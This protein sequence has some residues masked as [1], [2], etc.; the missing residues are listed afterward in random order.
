MPSQANPRASPSKLAT[1]SRKCRGRDALDA[2][3]I[4]N[5]RAARDP[6][7]LA[8][9][10]KGDTHAA[11][12]PTL[13]ICSTRI[14][15]QQLG[16]ERRSTGKDQGLL[17]CVQNPAEHMADGGL[18]A[19]VNLMRVNGDGRSRC[20]VQQLAALLLQVLVAI[21]RGLSLRPAFGGVFQK[22]P[23]GRPLIRGTRAPPLKQDVDPGRV[24]AAP[25]EHGQGSTLPCSIALGIASTTDPSN[26]I[27]T[28]WMILAGSDVFSSRQSSPVPVHGTP[29]HA[30]GQ[31]RHLPL[32]RRSPG[33]N[34][35]PAEDAVECNVIV[36]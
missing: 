14:T 3:A 8:V 30:I 1:R 16:V 24:D 26:S 11:A 13:H 19:N 18:P 34:K 23:A 15:S 12:G 27:W 28:T 21:P 33:W 2:I 17:T 6:A 31:R 22:L 5:G 29:P 4:A 25:P 9:F 20:S 10:T 32:L 7:V 36:L 35:I